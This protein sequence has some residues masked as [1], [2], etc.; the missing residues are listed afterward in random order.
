MGMHKVDYI[1]R[2]PWIAD[3]NALVDAINW[4]LDRAQRK[5]EVVPITIER[6][7]KDYSFFYW[8]E[9]GLPFEAEFILT[10]PE[11]ATRFFSTYALTYKETAQINDVIIKWDIASINM[12]V[13]ETI[14]EKEKKQEVIFE[15]IEAEPVVKPK[16]KKN[17]KKKTSWN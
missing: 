3:Y 12:R 11:D 4:L 7:V 10:S 5:K 17:G 8:Q 2:Q 15:T 1:R 9:V 6:Q 14:T 13:V 16:R